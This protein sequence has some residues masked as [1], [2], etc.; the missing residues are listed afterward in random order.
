MSLA[1][2]AIN[3]VLAVL[4]LARRL[5]CV[6]PGLD[7]RRALESCPLIDRAWILSSGSSAGSVGGVLGVSDSLPVSSDDSIDSPLD[8]KPWSLPNDALCSGLRLS[9]GIL[10]GSIGI[11]LSGWLVSHVGM[12]LCWYI[13]TL[14][15]EKEWRRLDGRMTGIDMVGRRHECAA[16]QMLVLHCV[17]RKRRG[18][19]YLVLRGVSETY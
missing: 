12:L 14:K 4:A 18:M 5:F 16:Q 3:C 13:L 2:L 10:F 6:C 17:L 1:F 9:S 7:R 11:G 15:E 8:R 19:R